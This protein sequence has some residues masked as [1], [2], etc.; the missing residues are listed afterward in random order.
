MNRRER[1]D[2]EA[3]ESEL[4]EDGE[5][6]SSDDE[7]EG[8]PFFFRDAMPKR[9]EADE[10]NTSSH[11]EIGYDFFPSRPLVS[12]FPMSGHVQFL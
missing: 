9:A 12:P 11:D 10:R 5:I 1:S 2:A 7:E 6:E 4:S 3:M 8:N